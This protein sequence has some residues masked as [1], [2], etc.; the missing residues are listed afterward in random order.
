MFF[1]QHLLI[2]HVELSACVALKGLIDLSSGVNWLDRPN[3]EAHHPWSCK[4]RAKGSPEE[5]R[6]ADR[7]LVNPVW[8]RHQRVWV[9]ESLLF[10]HPSEC[11]HTYRFSAHYDAGDADERWE[12][13]HRLRE[14]SWSLSLIHS[15]SIP[16]FLSFLS[17]FIRLFQKLNVSLYNLS[18]PLQLPRV[19]G[20]SLGEETAS[21][22]GRSAPWPTIWRNSNHNKNAF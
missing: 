21:Y 8:L 3:A 6:P 10:F 18:Q 7:G 15:L 19:S 2:T 13:A 20:N 12:W 22:K 16:S 1:F 4:V 9:Q 17:F 11:V 14:V 5:T